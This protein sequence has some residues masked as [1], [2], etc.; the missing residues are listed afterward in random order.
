MEVV[1]KIRK[2]AAGECPFYGWNSMDGTH[3]GHDKFHGK[4]ATESMILPEEPDETIPAKCPLREESYV[5][6]YVIEKQ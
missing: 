1:F 5:A 2:C 6:T 3:C 4:D